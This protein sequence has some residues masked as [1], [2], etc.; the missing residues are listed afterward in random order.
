MPVWLV[1]DRDLTPVTASAGTWVLRGLSVCCDPW[2]LVWVDSHTAP[3]VLYT[4]LSLILPAF[5]PRLLDLA[6]DPGI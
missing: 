6:Q 5:V 3:T 4:S 1:E 2:Q